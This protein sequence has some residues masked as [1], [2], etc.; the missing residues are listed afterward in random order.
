M[1]IGEANDVAVLLHVLDGTCDI[2]PDHLL[3]VTA[4]VADRAGKALQLTIQLDHVEVEHRL[5]LLSGGCCCEDVWADEQIP[6][7]P[8]QNVPDPRGL[9]S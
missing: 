8:V 4:R 6:Y 9:L 3:E 2:T 7:R 1:N 5:L